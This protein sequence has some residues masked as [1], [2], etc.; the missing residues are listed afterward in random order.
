MTSYEQIAEL[1]ARRSSPTSSRASSHDGAGLRPAD[2]RHPP[3][4]RRRGGIGEDVVYDALDHVALQDAGPVLDLAGE[5]TIDSFSKL[6]EGLDLF[7]TPPEREVSGNYRRWA[8]ESAALDLA[9]RQ[10][11]TSLHETL[12]R[13]PQ[14]VNFVVSMR[15]APLPGGRGAE[16]STIEPVRERLE[17]YPDLRFKLDP[18]NDWTDELI[19]ELVETGAVDSLDLKGQYKGT[20]VDVETDPSSTGS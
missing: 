9:L 3:Q 7:P 17:V 8:F 19:A 20:P 2:H 18:T 10:A 1:P 4:G 11:G 12:G 16:P 14:P 6:L 5:H 15:L 13:E